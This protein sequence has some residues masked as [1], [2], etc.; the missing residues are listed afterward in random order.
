MQVTLDMA[1]E[2]ECLVRLLQGRSNHRHCL[3]RLLNTFGTQISALT[4]RL[5]RLRSW[6]EH[7]TSH[8]RW[9]AESSKYVHI[10]NHS[11]ASPP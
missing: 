4:S 6:P 10:C 8:V 5:E 9:T 1:R 2:P 11:V 7:A 3:H